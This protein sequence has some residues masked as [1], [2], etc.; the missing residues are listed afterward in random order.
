MQFVDDAS[1]KILENGC[2]KELDKIKNKFLPA[3]IASLTAIG[4]DTSVEDV[5]F[6]AAAPDLVIT[7]QS[8]S[9]VWSIVKGGL[10]KFY[11]ISGEGKEL[12]DQVIP[13]FVC[14]LFVC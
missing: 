14:L 9:D 12:R 5:A 4:E 7:E 2:E 3:S 6:A 10:D 8:I 13:L 1:L 11:R